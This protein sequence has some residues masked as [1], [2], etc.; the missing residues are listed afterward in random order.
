VLIVD[1]VV[2]F[3][4]ECDFSKIDRKSCTF[5]I[6]KLLSNYSYQTDLHSTLLENILAY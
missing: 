2:V 5:Y 3:V 4:G 6:H 1:V